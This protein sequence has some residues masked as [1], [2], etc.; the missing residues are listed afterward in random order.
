MPKV[1]R[2]SQNIMHIY[3]YIYIYYIYIYIKGSHNAKTVYDPAGVYK[4]V[5]MVIR[6]TIVEIRSN[7]DIQKDEAPVI[8]SDP[9]ENGR[10]QL[11]LLFFSESVH[12]FFSFQYEPKL[13]SFKISGC[14]S[15]HALG[16]VPTCGSPR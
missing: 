13:P 8:R 11:L 3:I 16:D 7:S 14:Q 4:T 6:V 5:T 1:L 12:M 10:L 9:V 2:E 15:L